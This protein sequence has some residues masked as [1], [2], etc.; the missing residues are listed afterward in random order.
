VE[1]LYQHI[2]S[3]IEN[4]DDCILIK[5]SEEGDFLTYSFE[6]APYREENELIGKLRRVPKLRRDFRQKNKNT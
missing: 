5:R 3:N 6:T 2:S 4:L 1:N